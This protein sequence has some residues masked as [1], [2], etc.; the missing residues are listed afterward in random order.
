MLGSGELPSYEDCH[1]C[2]PPPDYCSAGQTVLDVCGCCQGCAKGENEECGGL[3]GTDG[4]CADYLQCVREDPEDP[5]NERGTCQR[6]VAA[7]C[8]RRVRNL[9]GRST[10]WT[11]RWVLVTAWRAVPTGRREWLTALYTAWETSGTVI[12]SIVGEIEGSFVL[13]HLMMFNLLNNRTYL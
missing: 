2:P 8:D 3:W 1:F 7:C 5:F 11:R 4:T 12:A 10:L 6:T 13:C 9:L